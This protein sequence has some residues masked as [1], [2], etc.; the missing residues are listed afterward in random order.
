ME[1]VPEEKITADEDEDIDR[2]ES[3]EM[4]KPEDVDDEEDDEEEAVPVT[5]PVPY[6][7]ATVAHT[8]ENR[9]PESLRMNRYPREGSCLFCV[10]M[11]SISIVE[12]LS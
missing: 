12:F 8:I 7:L 9:F 5:T 1:E 4:E 6:S 10:F 2:V 3:A 11:Q